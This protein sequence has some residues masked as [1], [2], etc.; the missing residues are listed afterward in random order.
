[1]ALRWIE[2]GRTGQAL[3]GLDPTGRYLGQVVHYDRPA[4]WRAYVRGYPVAGRHASAEGAQAA[5][6]AVVARAAALRGP[7]AP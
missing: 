5:V 7:A 4:G 2:D 3:R 6:E 1:M